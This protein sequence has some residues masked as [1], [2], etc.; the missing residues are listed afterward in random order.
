MIYTCSVATLR[1]CVSVQALNQ[2]KMLS[3]PFLGT[4]KNEISH[5]NIFLLQRKQ[6]E[7][8]LCN[9]QRTLRIYLESKANFRQNFFKWMGV[10]V[11]P[12]SVV[13]IDENFLSFCIQGLSIQNSE[14]SSNQF[15]IC[16]FREKPIK[17]WAWTWYRK[18]QSI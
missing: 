12:W 5:F 15:S 10:G 11:A 7:K 8:F 1:D 18:S 14:L 3:W 9:F 2:K 4:H 6:T 17:R 13:S 16:R